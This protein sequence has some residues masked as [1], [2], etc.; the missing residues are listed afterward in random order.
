MKVYVVIAGEYSDKHVEAVCLTREMAEAFAWKKL[1][2]RQRQMSDDDYDY[3]DDYEYISDTYMIEEFDIFDDTEVLEVASGKATF[4]FAIIR[5]KKSGELNITDCE[6][7]LK[8]D[9]DR[10][11]NYSLNE[12]HE[13]L[14]YYVVHVMAKD[15]KEAIKIASDLFAEYFAMKNGI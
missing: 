4:I 6:I 14:Y 2:T 5:S 10:C 8:C 1:N 13:G 7:A 11:R 9:R 15:E 3:T 12:I